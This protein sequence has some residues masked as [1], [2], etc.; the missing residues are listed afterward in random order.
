MYLYAFYMD[1][2]EATRLL[3]HTVI[4][5]PILILVHSGLIASRNVEYV[6]QRMP[7][8]FRGNVSNTYGAFLPVSFEFSLPVRV[9]VRPRFLIGSRTLTD[10]TGGKGNTAPAY[11]AL[12][13]VDDSGFRDSETKDESPP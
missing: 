5:N 4:L 11:R 8:G 12:P 7:F 1:L 3:P 9:D 13:R 2:Y 6:S 10:H